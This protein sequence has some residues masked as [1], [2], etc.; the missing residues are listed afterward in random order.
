M[1]ESSKEDDCE[2]RA[3]ILD[4]DSNIVLEHWTRADKTAEVAHD[5]HQQRDDDG[6]IEGLS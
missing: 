6:K 2:W 4:E 5:E 3:I 1:H